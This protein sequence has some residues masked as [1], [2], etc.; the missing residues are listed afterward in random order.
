MFLFFLYCWVIFI[1]PWFLCNNCSFCAR[2]EGFFFSVAPH[3]RD[4]QEDIGWKNGN[5]TA[6]SRRRLPGEF[7]RKLKLQMFFWKWASDLERIYFPFFFFLNSSFQPPA[8][9]IKFFRCNTRRSI[10]RN[11]EITILFLKREVVEETRIS[12]FSA[13]IDRFPV[14]WCR[15][16]LF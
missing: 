6:E 8:D 2:L 15:S 10:G 7:H 5:Q 11:S 3:A 16:I 9:M 13:E 12:C 14:F 1:F 4:W